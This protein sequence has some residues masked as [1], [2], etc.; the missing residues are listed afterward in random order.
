[1]ETIGKSLASLHGAMGV[2]GQINLAFMPMPSV[3]KRHFKVEVPV[4]LI[5]SSRSSVDCINNRINRVPTGVIIHLQAL[6][7][8]VF[9]CLVLI[10]LLNSFSF[11]FLVCK[12][13][14]Q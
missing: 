5:I 11:D 1:M 14:E 10:T 2:P 7:S 3:K 13:V 6:C 8:C 4:Q 9:I 12:E